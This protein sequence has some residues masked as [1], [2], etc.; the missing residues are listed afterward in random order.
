MILNYKIYQAKPWES[1]DL[2]NQRR[3]LIKKV[4][5]SIIDRMIHYS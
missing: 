4:D 5:A 3:E 2:I 1:S